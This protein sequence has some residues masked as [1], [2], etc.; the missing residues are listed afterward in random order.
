MFYIRRFSSIDLF[1]QANI[2]VDSQ[3]TARIS[4][5]GVSFINLTQQRLSQSTS[6]PLTPS[7][8]GAGSGGSSFSTA[9]GGG[10]WRYMAPE[11]LL[12]GLY[13]CESS[14]AT[15]SSDIFSLA[16][17]IY[18]VY[19]GHIPYPESRLEM[20]LANVA[21]HGTRPSRPLILHSDYLWNLVEG[22][23]RQ[24]CAERY[25]IETVRAKIHKMVGQD[26]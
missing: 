3:G 23:W 25:N 4:D 18:E 20:V 13:G 22:C 7:V 5:F 21:V 15:F 12:P 11:R 8:D 26:L 2:L 1:I 6:H 17:V 9:S 10:T 14:R 24:D 16:M 19:S